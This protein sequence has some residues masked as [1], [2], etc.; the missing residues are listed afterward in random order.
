[1]LIKSIE[2]GMLQVNCY[3]IADRAAG[4]AI[5]VDPGDEPDRIIDI[6]KDNSLEVEYIVCTHGHFDHV[7]AV[8]ELKKNTGAKVVIHRDELAIYRAALDMAAFWGHEIDPLPEPDMLVREGDKI[9]AGDLSFEVFHTPGHSPGGICLYS[10]DIV[11]TGDTLFAGS[12]GRTDF[13]GGD[14]GLLKKSFRRLMALP[15]NTKVLAG[16]G[17]STTIG[18]EKKENMFAGEFLS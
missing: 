10:G 7:G 9:K 2:V 11:V 17:G 12:V 3:V 18:K 6:I 8:S 14:A 5:V 1:M 16:H 13:T 4:K 15:E